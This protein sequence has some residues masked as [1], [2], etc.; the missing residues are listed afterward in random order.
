MSRCGN[1]AKYLEQCF[2]VYNFSD[3]VYI[4]L[5]PSSHVLIKKSI[6]IY[7]GSSSSQI[8]LNRAD[9]SSSSFSFFTTYLQLANIVSI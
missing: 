3:S 7:I 8:I 6:T 1:W 2:I 4:D 5:K 9:Y